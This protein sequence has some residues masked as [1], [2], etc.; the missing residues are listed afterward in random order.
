MITAG[1]I[2]ASAALGALIGF[3]TNWLAI[4]SLFRPLRP[5]WYSLGWQGVI[6]RNREKLAGNI[7]RVVGV[8]LLSRDY[9]LEQVQGTILQENLHRFVAGQVE[10]LLDASLASAF[11][12]LPP[13]WR[14]EGLDKVVRRGF[15][16][17]VEWSDGE[18]ALELKERLLDTLEN[19]LGQMQVAQILSAE[20]LD[21]IIATA[22]GVLVRPD[23]RDHLTQA[24][25]RQLEE[26]LD[27]ETPLEEI[28]PAELRDLLHARLQREVPH[29]VERLARWLVEPENV[30]YLGE[31]IFRALET[32]AEGE[33][34]LKR[35][36]GEL[37]LRLFREQILE[38]VRR[39]LPQVAQEYLHSRE[40]RAKISEHLLDSINTFLRKPIREVVGEYRRVLAE[41]VGFIAGTWIA[42]AEMQHALGR[43][44]RHQYRQHGKRQLQEV[45]PQMV[46][47][48]LRRRLLAAL[49]VPPDKV[50]PWSR[51]LSAFLRHRLQGSHV[52]FREWAGLE[53]EDEAVLVQKAQ[54]KATQILEAEVPVLVGQFDI[55]A[56]VHAKVMEFDLL[57]VER[58]IKDIISDQLR[59]INLLGAVLGGLV[60]LL[61]PFL[62]AYIAA[63]H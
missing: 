48:E 13:A 59:Y 3:G 43:F 56:I 30:E 26:Y 32:Y 41:R 28:V 53:G 42:S 25:Q 62:N 40:V 36:L 12:Q 57:R 58:L 33:K 7:S 52:P 29:I 27:A 60:G 31:R 46:W 24:L 2:A 61:L 39:R 23:V 37:G 21:E 54:D 8:D 9:L 20:Q 4:K 50:E 11:G 15:Q 17:L 51:Q 55:E 14:Q 6:P 63:L 16:L 5:R 38:A 1:Q 19:Y 22:G 45:V 34:P 47:R 18:A 35:L 49:Q 44:L 10:R